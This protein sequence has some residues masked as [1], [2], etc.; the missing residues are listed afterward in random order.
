MHNGIVDCCKGSN[1][2]GHIIGTMSKTQQCRCEDQRH[3]EESI[4]THLVVAYFAGHDHAGGY[5]VRRGVHHVTVKGMVEAPTENAYAVVEVYQ[6]RLREI[7]C[8]KE[9]TRELRLEDG[10]PASGGQ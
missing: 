8:G 3:R 10:V 2:I 7:G 4:D 9:P 6:D 1:G 5:A